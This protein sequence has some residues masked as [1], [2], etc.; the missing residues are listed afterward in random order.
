MASSGSTSVAVTSHDT[1][2]FSWSRSSYSI[3]GNY[4]VISWSLQLI[5][6]SY[7]RI[8]STASKSW[9]VT[10]NGTAYSGTNTVGISASSTKTLASNT[11]TI[12][13][14][15]DGSKTFSYSFSQ[16]FGITFSGSTV[17]TKSGSGNGTLD[18]I[19]RQAS[20]STAPNFNDEANP[21]ITY[22]NPA[23]N[24]VTS[25]QACISLTGAAAD[26]P[27]RDISKTGTSYTFNLTDAER[28]TLRNATTTANSRDVTFFVRTEIG[29]STY[30][31]TLKKTLTI[32]NANP[33]F[34]A[35]AVDTGTSSTVLTGGSSKMIKG[36]NSIAASITDAAAY[37][38]A[39]IKSY[40][41]TNGSNIFNSATAA[42]SN[43]E[44]NVFAFEITDSR[45]NKATK[46]I[47]LDMVDYVPLTCNVDG[48]INLSA[49]DSTQ[50]ELTFTISGNYYNGSF[51]AVANELTIAYT[52]EDSSGGWTYEELDITQATFDGNTYTLTHT[53]PNLEYT[54]SYV[55]IGQVSDKIN[56]NIQSTSKTLKTTPIFD[57]G[58]N[59]FNF[60]VPVSIQGGKCYAEYVLY[61]GGATNGAVTLADSVV[62]Y[63]Y[64]EI[65][66]E[67]NNGETGGYT[68]MYQPNGKTIDINI[69]EGAE[70]IQTTYIRRTFY[71]V[72]GNTVTPNITGAGYVLFQ[73]STV[74]HTIGTN[75][76]YITRIVGYK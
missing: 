20:I 33:T 11:T 49:D 23:G 15:S 55:I 16:Y 56:G 17:G 69:V 3:S 60:N 26:V 21:S 74:S 19:P 32:V 37:K 6:D 22:S 27:Y 8:S 34:T 14:N 30:Y 45:G 57:W 13:H 47:T 64:I 4:S 53:I 68:K 7:G 42:L 9:S 75:Y 50:A 12:Y 5:S 72:N 65:F 18:T 28:A 70:S 43:T 40:K 25:L 1:L 35:S 2:K 66:F 51:G 41:I 52:K 62:N 67:D 58:E 73:N 54:N 36:F 71:K 31:S 46:S 59:D 76:I 44:S 48:K 61:D 39:T 24:S 38:G 63:D 29:G 10:V